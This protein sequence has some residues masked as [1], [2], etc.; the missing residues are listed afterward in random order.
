[1][2]IYDQLDYFICRELTYYFSHKERGD[3]KIHIG[4]ITIEK[5]GRVYK[6]KR[7]PTFI[8]DILRFTINE[9][10]NIVYAFYSVKTSLSVL[11]KVMRD[12][13]ID[14]EKEYYDP[15]N[16]KFIIPLKLEQ[17]PQHLIEKITQYGLSSFYYNEDQA[18]YWV[19]F[20]LIFQNQNEKYG[21]FNSD[22]SILL[23]TAI[24]LR[25]LENKAY[26]IIAKLE[27]NAFLS[28][29][30]LVDENISYA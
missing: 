23:T 16:K 3:F 15:L 22:L 19:L 6:I 5:E 30:E 28:D 20:N 12:F 9:F 4:Q 11:G 26:E 2:E 10:N 8:K 17:Q 7:P 18:N 13:S 29:V 1:M 27:Q 25:E 14:G 24:E 21:E